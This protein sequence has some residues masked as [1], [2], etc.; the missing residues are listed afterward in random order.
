MGLQRV[1]F[2]TTI[3]KYRPKLLLKGNVDHWGI[4]SILWFAL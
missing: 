1:R 3:F 2:D 4:L